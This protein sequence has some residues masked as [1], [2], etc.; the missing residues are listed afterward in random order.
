MSRHRIYTL[1]LSVKF[2]SYL[3]PEPR[4]YW[5]STGCWRVIVEGLAN[6]RLLL[7]KFENFPADCPIFQIFTNNI[8][9]IS[10]ESSKDVP[11]YSQLLS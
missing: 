5:F 3:H 11:A 8:K 10:I 7:P 6:L 4:A 2:R 9:R 1:N